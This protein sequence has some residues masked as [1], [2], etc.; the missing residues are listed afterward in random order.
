MQACPFCGH[1]VKVAV[2][3]QINATMNVIVEGDRLARLTRT[4]MDV[5]QVI[6]DRAPRCATKDDILRS[7]YPIEADEPDVKIIDVFVCKI[8]RKIKGFSFGIDT[9]WGRGFVFN[10]KGGEHAGSAKHT[11]AG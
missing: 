4:E 1:E 11:E 8:R 3:L 7:V 10:P 2:P 6:M 5:F 9:V